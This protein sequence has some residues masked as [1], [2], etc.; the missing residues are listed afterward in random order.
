[1]QVEFLCS[2]L[3]RLCT[4]IQMLDYPDRN[5]A[6]LE[7]DFEQLNNCVTHARRVIELRVSRNLKSRE[8]L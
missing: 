4:F 8:C 1:M 7:I 2:T 5:C 3:Q 6:V